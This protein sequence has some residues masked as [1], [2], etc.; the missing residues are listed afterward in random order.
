MFDPF[1]DFA[2]AGYLRNK[3]QEKD[4]RVI[5]QIEHEVFSR[6]IQKAIQHL[7]SR[8]SIDYTDFLAVH[9]ILFSEFYP[10]AGQDRATT[11]PNIWIKKGTVEFCDAVDCQRAINDGLRR[12][13]SKE[14]MRQNVG[15]VMG[16]FAHGHPFLDGNG[17]T[18]LLVHMELCYRAGFSIAWPD[19][20]KDAY[21]KALTDELDKPY[22]GILDGYLSQFIVRRLERDEWGKHIFSIKGLDGLDENNVVVGDLND[23]AIAELYRLRDKKRSYEQISDMESGACDKC[24]AIPCICDESSSAPRPKPF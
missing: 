12:G 4:A 16:C 9:R 21:L 20:D 1:K 3:F 5:K 15:T 8:R 18:L 17:R 23:P 19:S 2:T 7:A 13:S 6:H 10:W 11:A 24:H 14:D 22:K